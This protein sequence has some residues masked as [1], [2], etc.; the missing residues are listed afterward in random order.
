M[1]ATLPRYRNFCVS[2]NQAIVL[3]F[4]IPHPTRAGDDVRGFHG[5]GLLNSFPRPGLSP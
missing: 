3:Y 2:S 5:V 4:S 1:T